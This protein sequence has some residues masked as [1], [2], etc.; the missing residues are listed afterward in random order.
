M[1]DIR[2][3]CHECLICS[4]PEERLE[5]WEKSTI[6]E[7]SDN[8]EE[9]QPPY[10]KAQE[11]MKGKGGEDWRTPYIEWII[12]G[13]RWK[14]P[15]P[16]K[17]RKLIKN[18]SQFFI[19]KEGELHRIFHNNTTKK[20][21]PENYVKNYIKTLHIRGKTNSTNSTKKLVSKGP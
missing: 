15:L 5:E 1:R 12:Y 10:L 2:K 6:I 20:C 9:E 14:S 8:S 18:R 4:Q 7:Y 13:K 16:E 3:Y 21:I 17:D 19:L 11:S